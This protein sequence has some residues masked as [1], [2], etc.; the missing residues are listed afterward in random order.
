MS[1]KL[2]N[3]MIDHV[4]SAFEDITGVAGQHSIRDR[5][6]VWLVRLW[7]AIYMSV[8]DRL[9]CCSFRIEYARSTVSISSGCYYARRSY[10]AIRTCC[11]SSRKSPS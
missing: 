1:A 6:V 5:F 7:M 11:R 3:R 2:T 9:V 10:A 8:C 4:M